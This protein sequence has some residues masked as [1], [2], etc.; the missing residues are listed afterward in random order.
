MLRKFSLSFFLLTM[1]LFY[2]LPAFAAPGENRLNPGEGMNRGHQ[3]VSNNGLYKLVFQKD[4]NLV[5]K[6][7]GTTLWS[8]N[9]YAA[10]AVVMDKNGAL[11]IWTY[12]VVLW[13]SGTHNPGAYLIVQDDGNVVIYKDQTALWS[14][15]T[16]Q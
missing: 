2:S 10:W 8:S 4:G 15:G 1:M 5:L 12:P 14:T 3:L 11:T 13:S 16:G 6:G 7:R 9:T